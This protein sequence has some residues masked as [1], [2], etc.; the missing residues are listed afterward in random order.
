M[1]MDLVGW[2]RLSCAGCARRIPTCATCGTQDCL[3]PSCYACLALRTGF[4]K[5]S[6]W[7]ASLEQ[8]SGWSLSARP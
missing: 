4:P 1:E 7:T 5:N 2:S 6:Y 8:D 3:D